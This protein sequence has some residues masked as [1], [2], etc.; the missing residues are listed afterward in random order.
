ML[1]RLKVSQFYVYVI[2]SK[3]LLYDFMMN[4]ERFDCVLRC[5]WWI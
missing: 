3:C 4:Q 1:L 2:T 5:R